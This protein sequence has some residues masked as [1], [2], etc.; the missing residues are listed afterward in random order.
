MR[1]QEKRRSGLGRGAIAEKGLVNRA[2]RKMS[3]DLALSLYA[4]AKAV[5]LY[6]SLETLHSLECG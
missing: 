6:I 2:P 3:R 4:Q 5:V 1:N